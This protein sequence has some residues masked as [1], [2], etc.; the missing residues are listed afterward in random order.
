VLPTFSLTLALVLLWVLLTGAPPASWVVGAPAVAAAVLAGRLLH[1]AG[2]PRVPRARL[3]A[4]LA[5]LPYFLWQ[6][7]RGGWDVARRALRPSLPLAPGR[8]TYDCRLP[9][10]PA[11]TFLANVA[12]LL[13]GTLYLGDA[14]GAMEL[15]VVDRSQPV[16]A[17]L[18]DLEER[19][20]R[21]FGQDQEGSR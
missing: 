14:A 20:A 19:V 7:L 4:A 13:P 10:G 2:V 21:I 5:F 3:L 16:Q 11:R 17:E 9:P 1:P 6:S 18:A 12:S 8:T 15:H